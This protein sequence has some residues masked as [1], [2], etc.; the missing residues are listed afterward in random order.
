LTTSKLA[1]SLDAWVT[2]IL[3]MELIV[4]FLLVEKNATEEISTNYFGFA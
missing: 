4:V 1:F 3:I 2:L